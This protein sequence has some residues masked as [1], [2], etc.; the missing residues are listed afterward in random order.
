MPAERSITSSS[1]QSLK[2]CLSGNPSG[3]FAT[4]KGVQV[5]LF[6]RRMN[7]RLFVEQRQELEKKVQSIT[8][9]QDSKVDFADFL[10]LMKWMVTTN[11]S[12]I[13]EIAEKVV[14]QERAW[15]CLEDETKVNPASILPA[16]PS[17]QSQRRKSL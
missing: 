9:R 13:N 5:V 6:S 11:F 1:T 16:T 12:K 8:G 14:D 7:M 4:V 15:R 2:E 10:R 17:R 3:A